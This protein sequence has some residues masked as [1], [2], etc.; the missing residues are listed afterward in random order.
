MSCTQFRI[1]EWRLTREHKVGFQHRLCSCGQQCLYV[2][3]FLSIAAKLDV[4]NNSDKNVCGSYISW[5]PCLFW[6]KYKNSKHTWFVFCF[7]IWQHHQIIQ[8][9]MVTLENLLFTA[10]LDH[11]ILAVFQQFCALQA[12]G[13]IRGQ[14]LVCRTLVNLIFFFNG[15]TLH[16]DGRIFLT[17]TGFHVLLYKTIEGSKIKTNCVSIVSLKKIWLIGDICEVKY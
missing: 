14:S 4:L 15:R 8:Q 17:K 11:H 6:Y 3:L 1:Y 5:L 13:I 7:F 12:W 2:M 9:Y 10:E 16:G